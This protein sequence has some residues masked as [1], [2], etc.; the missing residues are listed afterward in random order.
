MNKII[1]TAPAHEYLINRLTALG[2]EVIYEPAISYEELEN[3][4]VDAKGLVV[5]TRIKIDKNLI[6]KAPSLQWIG[7]LGSG[8]E[9]IDA[10]YARSKNIKC[11]SSPEGNRN[12]VA[13]HALGLL[14]NLANHISRSNEEIKNG[15]WRRNEN[16]GMELDGKTIGIIGYGNTGAA[17]ARLLQPFGI[18]VLV[19]DKY[20]YDFGGGYIKEASLEQLCRYS[21]FISFHLPLTD[22]T[23]H[24]ANAEFFNALEQKPYFISTCRGKVTDTEALITALKEGMIAGAGLDVLENEKLDAYTPEEKDQLNFL[25]FHPNVILTPHIA[26]YTHDSFYK[27]AKVLLEKLGFDGWYG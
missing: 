19:Y 22:E 11:V 7:R 26:G 14:L 23:Y 3:R 2:N 25:A 10:A 4:I 1:I 15:H 9:L 16:R 20:K 12:A 21:N 27:M 5:T 6:D 18:T 13:E 8:M 17:F 24:M